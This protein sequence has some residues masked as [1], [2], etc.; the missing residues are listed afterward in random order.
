VSRCPRCGTSA[1]A[2]PV[3]HYVPP[4]S[5]RLLRERLDI[6]RR[7][8]GLSSAGEALA[9]A[10]RIVALDLNQG[11][12]VGSGD[13]GRSRPGYP[14][15]EDDVGEHEQEQPVDAVEETSAED[16]PVDSGDGGAGTVVNTDGGDAVVDGGDGGEGGSDEGEPASE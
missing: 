3:I 7:E 1:D 9:A 10:V 4:R 2:V 6:I 16:A 5:A 15:Q 13:A 14:T 11:S 8:L 12:R